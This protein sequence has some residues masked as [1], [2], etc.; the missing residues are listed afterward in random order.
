MKQFRLS[1]QTPGAVLTKFFVYDGTDI[2]G[3]I[4]VPNEEA[5][6]LPKHWLGGATQP[7]AAAPTKKGGA[8]AAAFKAAAKR[9]GAL[10]PAPAANRSRR[11]P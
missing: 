3:S 7:Q 9:P 6:D 11:T 5:D 2:I 8:L 1:R 10:A 4:D